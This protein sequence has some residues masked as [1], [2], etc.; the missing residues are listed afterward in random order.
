MNKMLLTIS[1][2]LITTSAYAEW[3]FFFKSHTGNDYYYDRDSIKRN[4]NKIKVWS[5]ANFSKEEL[6]NPRYLNYPSQMS[7]EEYDCV[8]E[9]RKILKVKSYSKP[10]LNGDQISEWDELKEKYVPPDTNAYELM[11]RVCKK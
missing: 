6:K 10:D 2:L 8:T 1:I 3:E 9:T 11:K 4:K 5:Y 7:L